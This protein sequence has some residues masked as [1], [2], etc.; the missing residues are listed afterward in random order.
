MAK[1]QNAFRLYLHQANAVKFWKEGKHRESADEYWE[2]FQLVPS[3]TEESR[4]HILHGYTSILREEYFVASDTDLERMKKLYKA[5]YEPRLFRVE[6]GFTLGL[7]LYIRGERM[8]CAEYYYGTIE[9][10]ERQVN[11][12]EA[13]QEK[14]KMR[15]NHDLVSMKELMDRVVA[16]ARGN[17]RNLNSKTAKYG[18]PPMRMR[19]DGS[20]TPV[21]NSCQ[22]M[23]VGPMGTTLTMEQLHKLIDV[24]GVECDY[25]HRT[26]A[27]L[28]KC[29]KCQKA[30]YCSRECQ[31][32]QWKEKG[33]KKH[34][35]K[36]GEFKGGD[37]VQLA[38]LQKKP[39]LNGQIVRIVEP[40]ATKKDRYECRV[41]GGLKG[42]NGQSFVVAATNLNQLRPFDICT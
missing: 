32:K 37:L 10:G 27:K 13:K 35:R 8:Q 15:L 23:S 9:I 28:L 40:H 7:L 34:C 30:F 24:G 42:V 1:D 25:C 11:P 20:Y 5:K 2:C 29:T 39:E 19:S 18:P 12:K 36:E 26:D 22:G 3:L 31:A 4:Y 16:E 21:P 14:K 6:A 33:H 17:W 38:R 41:E